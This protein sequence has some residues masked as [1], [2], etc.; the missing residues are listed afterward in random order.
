M[1]KDKEKKKYL[2]KFKSPIYEEYSEEE[3]NEEIK[4]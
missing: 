3:S 1:S 4:N 2:V